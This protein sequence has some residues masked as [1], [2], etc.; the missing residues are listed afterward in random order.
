MVVGIKQTTRPGKSILY[1][2][3]LNLYFLKS[4]SKEYKKYRIIGDLNS[5]RDVAKTS[6]ET[7]VADTKF[8]VTT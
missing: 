2:G 5:H 8:T 3:G 1:F 7:K 6:I 4:L